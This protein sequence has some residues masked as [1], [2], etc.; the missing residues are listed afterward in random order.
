MDKWKKNKIKKFPPAE[1]GGL[2]LQELAKTNMPDE[3]AW[4]PPL[5][6]PN[7]FGITSRFRNT[8]IVRMTPR[9][10]TSTLGRTPKSVSYFIHIIFFYK[11]FPFV[12]KPTLAR[13]AGS[14]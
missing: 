1:A 8:D 5:V 6:M 3:I 14:L 2:N 13:R 9:F 10:M 12:K 7:E 11:V 4:W